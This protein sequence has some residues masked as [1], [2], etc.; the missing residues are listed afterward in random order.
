[1]LMR[2]TCS[3]CKHWVSLN[4]R[5]EQGDVITAECDYELIRDKMGNEKFKRTKGSDNC[6]QHEKKKTST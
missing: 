5:H 3:N 1:M 4:A 2:R 6:G